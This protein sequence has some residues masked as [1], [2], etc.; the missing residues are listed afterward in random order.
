MTNHPVR[1]KISYLFAVG[2]VATLAPLISDSL[3]VAEIGNMVFYAV[4]LLAPYYLLAGLVKWCVGRMLPRLRLHPGVA[5][6]GHGADDRVVA[7]AAG[8]APAQTNGRKG[9]PADSSQQTP[10]ERKIEKA[11]NSPTKLEFVDT[12]FTRR[13][14]LPEGLS[15]DRN[16]VGQEGDGGREHRTGNVKVTKNIKGITLRSALRLMLR[17]LGLT[18]V[19]R[20][21]AA[22]HHDR[23]GRGST[24]DA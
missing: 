9:G 12:P 18:Y 2:L 5:G 4:C 13:D 7:A 3:E 15:P 17:E 10:A 6:G 24:D 21:R 14:R 8:R 11:L 22:H 20:R 19:I 23:G 16:P 1:K